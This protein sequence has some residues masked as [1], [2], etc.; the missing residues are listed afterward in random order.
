MAD[1]GK[2]CIALFPE[3]ET[4]SASTSTNMCKEMLDKEMLDDKLAA[5]EVARIDTWVGSK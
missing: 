2:H 5:A 3:I 1:F 4:T